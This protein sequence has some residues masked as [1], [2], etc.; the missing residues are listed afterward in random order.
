[1]SS[2]IQ[3]SETKLCDI[4]RQVAHGLQHIHSKNL[5]HLDMKPENIYVTPTG[6][7]KIGDFGLISMADNNS[8]EEG[9]W[10]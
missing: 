10:Y 9:D 8:F 7:Y 5:V 3:F 4:L 2:G 1:M 6:S